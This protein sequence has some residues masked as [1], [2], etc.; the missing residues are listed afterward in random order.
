[1]G[2]QILA[3]V[4]MVMVGLATWATLTNTQTPEERDEMLR[5]EDMWP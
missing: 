1:M 3:L 5:D 4:I 2:D